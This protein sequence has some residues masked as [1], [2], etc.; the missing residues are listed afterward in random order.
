MKSIFIKLGLIIATLC[1]AGCNYLDIVPDNVATIDIVFNNKVTAERYL[2]SCYWYIPEMG[3]IGADPGFDVG[4]EVMY[5]SDQ[6][7][8]F[9]NTT[10]F[11]ITMGNQNTNSPLVDFWNGE[12]WGKPLFRGINTCNIFIENVDKVP[13]LSEKEKLQWKAEAMVIKA[14]LHFYLMRV[15]GPI[16]INKKSTQIDSDLSELM[17]YRDKIDDIVDYCVSLIDECSK[18][19]PLK[20]SSPAS[21]M[22][23]ITKPAALAIKGKI[24]ATAASPFFNGN[25]NYANFKNHEGDHF[26]NQTD[27]IEK[28]SKA[29][30]ALKEAIDCAEEAGHDL[31]EHVNTSS[32]KISA[33]TKLSLTHRG[34]ITERWTKELVFGC[35][36]NG[37]T[38]MQIFCQPWLESNYSADDRYYNAKSTVAPTLEVAETFYS[39]NGVPINEDKN[40]MYNERYNTRVATEADIYYIKPNYSTANLNFDR[41]PRFYATLG[42][43]GSSWY[44]IGKFDDKDMWYLQSKAKQT[45]GKKSNRNYSITGYYAKKLVRYQNSMV[46]GSIVIDAYAFP[47]IR[48]ADLYL[49]YS[50]ALNEANRDKGGVPEMCYYYINLIRSRAGFPNGVVKDW[51]RYSTNPSKPLSYAGFREIIRQERMIELALEGQRFWDIKRWDLSIKY[52]NKVFKSW[53]VDKETTEEYYNLKSYFIREYRYRDNLWPLRNYD[54][55]VNSNLVQNPGW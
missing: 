30:V 49:L 20:V 33:E 29:V 39:K 21:D 9:I 8:D 53:D 1:V 19:L 54:L 52:F 55:I 28:W 35:G 2:S 40:W 12:N 7:S 27:D 18:D 43:D 31:Y 14:Y 47:I 36:G 13:D 5:Y 38:E 15:Y 11:W 24:L 25:T 26:F 37:I 17:T 45:S 42:F 51:E 48:L 10:T 22:G 46:P 3:K 32:D 34:K 44:G 16:P 41:E 23:R 50:E 4:D 6:S